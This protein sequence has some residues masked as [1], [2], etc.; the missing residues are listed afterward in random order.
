MQKSLT[1][2]L[3]AALSTLVVLVACPA[4]AS[5]ST[6]FGAGYDRAGG[7]P[8]VRHIQRGLRA[9]GYHCGPVDGL[10]GPWT[11]AAV[12]RFQARHGL[13]VTGVVNAKTRL[14]LAHR[15]L[16]VRVAPVNPTTKAASPAAVDSAPDPGGLPAIPLVLAL[17]SI[18]LVMLWPSVIAGLR[19]LHGPRTHW[20]GRTDPGRRTP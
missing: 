12:R 3:L 18:L 16:P 13:R 14:R 15:S 10:F 6:G 17:L 19:P 9:H 4:L 1:R 20:P 7:S 5:A 11:Q 2:C 8:V